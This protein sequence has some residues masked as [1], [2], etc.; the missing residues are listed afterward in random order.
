MNSKVIIIR[1]RNQK[2]NEIIIIE[3][4]RKDTKSTTFGF[5]TE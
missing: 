3:I 4:Y 5:K 2:R 1:Y